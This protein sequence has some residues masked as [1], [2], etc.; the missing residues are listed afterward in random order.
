M[1]DVRTTLHATPPP[2]RPHHREPKE[3][4]EWYARL[5]GMPVIFSLILESVSAL[6]VKDNFAL[7]RV[8][9]GSGN[10]IPSRRC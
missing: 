3:M 10:A 8:Q 9:L 6:G 1:S 7:G 4:S 5:L 2:L